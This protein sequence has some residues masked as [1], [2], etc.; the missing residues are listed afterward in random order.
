MIFM[1]ATGYVLV[2]LWTVALAARHRSHLMTCILGVG[3]YVAGALSAFQ[4]MAT[5]GEA[6]AWDALAAAFV[7]GAF[8]SQGQWR[9]DPVWV[10]LLRLAGVT[11]TG[12]AAW[13]SLHLARPPTAGASVTVVRVMRPREAR[14]HSVTYILVWKAIREAAPMLIVLPI[15]NILVG[16]MVSYTAGQAVTLAQITDST[17]SYSRWTWYLFGPLLMMALG[18]RFT[19]AEAHGKVADFLWS[20]PVEGA[21]SFWIKFWVGAAI[22]AASTVFFFGMAEL[23]FDRLAYLGKANDPMML[24]L[25]LMLV[26]LAAFCVALGAGTFIPFEFAASLAAAGV[27]ALWTAMAVTVAVLLREWLLTF[28]GFSLP[29]LAIALVASRRW[30]RGPGW[31]GRLVPTAGK[32]A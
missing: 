10:V 15:L 17:A 5:A 21:R 20:R 6:M 22:C 30:G 31:S 3:V 2:F 4:L 19:A 27:F 13:G 29:M 18:I 9:M 26:Q 12:A 28:A 24:A 32:L 14:T 8:A 7:P 25:I 11:I 23:L 1:G 16:W